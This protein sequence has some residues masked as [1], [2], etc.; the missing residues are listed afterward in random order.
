MWTKQWSPMD[1]WCTKSQ[2]GKRFS[3]ML[4]FTHYGCCASVLNA[5]I[6]TEES[7]PRSVAQIRRRSYKLHLAPKCEGEGSFTDHSQ[8]M[9]T[10]TVR[11][12]VCTRKF[13]PL[14]S[15]FEGTYVFDSKWICYQWTWGA[16]SLEK[17][18]KYISRFLKI[19][20]RELR[21]VSSSLHKRRTQLINV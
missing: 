19:S 17:W 10:D 20:F 6:P 2:P 12:N 21:I 1:L 15:I 4:G 13:I 8:S 14:S 3:A 11:D 16:Y 5:T 7:C 9:A 18:I